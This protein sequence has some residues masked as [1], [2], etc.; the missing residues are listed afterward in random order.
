MTP[1]QGK[2]PACTGPARAAPL[3]LEN[4]VLL[5]KVPSPESWGQTR[6]IMLSSHSE[7]ILA[8]TTE[9]GKTLPAESGGIQWAEK[10]KQVQE[11]ALIFLLRRLSSVSSDWG[12]VLF[13]LKLDL[14]K[15]FDTVVQSQ[16]RKLVMQK[17]AIEAGGPWEARAWMQ[18]IQW[19]TLHIS[20]DSGTLQIPQ[21]NGLRQ[22][23]PDSPV[24]F[25][26]L[27]PDRLYEIQQE[28]TNLPLPTLQG[29]LWT[30][31]IFGRSSRHTS[32]PQ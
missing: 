2:D 7:D 14:E 1:T 11:E 31:P 17:V 30:T 15:A 10:G 27:V 9:K 6:P 18:L 5:A 24:L 3:L 8:T 16:M 19:D 12:L 26:G 22:G 4:T 21:P 25:A 32:R 20:T 23:S 13:V 28:S 29:T